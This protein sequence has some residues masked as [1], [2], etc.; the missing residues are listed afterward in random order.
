M[1]DSILWPLHIVYMTDVDSSVSGIKYKYSLASTQ[2]SYAY[3]DMYQLNIVWEN[4]S[5]GFKSTGTFISF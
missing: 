2:F 5:T 3:P 4:L 1:P